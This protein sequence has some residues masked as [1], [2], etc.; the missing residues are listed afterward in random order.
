MLIIDH[1]LI[2]FLINR[3][4]DLEVLKKKLNMWSQISRTQSK[5][6]TMPDFKTKMSI[7]KNKN[8]CI[9]LE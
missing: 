2:I 1:L 6:F 9:I 4:F 8:N 3:L 7:I 5:T